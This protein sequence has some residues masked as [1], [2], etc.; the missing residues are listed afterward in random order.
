MLGIERVLRNAHERGQCR[1]G[2]P[3]CKEKALVGQE[4]VWFNKFKRRRSASKY[5]GVV[6]SA[7]SGVALVKQDT[8]RKVQI[9]IGQLTLKKDDDPYSLWLLV[10]S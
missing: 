4:V 5:R 2:C 9:A 10:Y 8:G 6:L 3:V 1:W 7:E